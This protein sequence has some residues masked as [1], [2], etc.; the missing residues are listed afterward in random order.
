MHDQLPRAGGESAQRCRRHRQGFHDHH[1][2]LHQRSA[3]A[4]SGAQGSLPGAR[5]RDQHDPDLDWCCESGRAGAAGIGRQARWR[6]HPRA[7]AECVGGRFQVRRQARHLKGRDQRRD[8][9]RRRAA[10]QGYSRLHRGA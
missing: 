7:D 2:R 9:A 6:R 3:H 4:R 1:S 5:S 8:E 10:A